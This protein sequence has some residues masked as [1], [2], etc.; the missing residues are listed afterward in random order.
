MRK[1]PTAI[2]DFWTTFQAAQ[3]W[4]VSE[5]RVRQLCAMDRVPGATLVGH[6]KR[7]TWFIPAKTIK[8]DSLREAAS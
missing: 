7:G 6:L 2:A 8:P 5:R 4:G 1:N 3:A